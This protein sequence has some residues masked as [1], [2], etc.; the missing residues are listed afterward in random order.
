MFCL[1]GNM[2]D[3]K[4][5]RDGDENMRDDAVG[6][7]SEVSFPFGMSTSIDELN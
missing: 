7:A 6:V 5:R 1:D 4:M 2:R 3:D